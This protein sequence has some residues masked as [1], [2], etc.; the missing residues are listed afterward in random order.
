[1]RIAAATGFDCPDFLQRERLL[2]R[3]GVCRNVR[4]LRSAQ[5]LLSLERQQNA[6]GN[7]EGGCKPGDEIIEPGIHFLPIRYEFFHIRAERP[8]VNEERL[9]ASGSGRAGD[10]R[11]NAVVQGKV[12]MS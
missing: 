12:P 4:R 6:R 11:R 5:L 9:A 3:G 8:V 1:M 10:R 2:R 7:N